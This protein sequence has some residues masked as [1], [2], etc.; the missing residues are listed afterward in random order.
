MPARSFVEGGT[1][2]S[3]GA[4]QP[5]STHDTANT[6][7]VPLQHVSMVSLMSGFD[8]DKDARSHA[9]C[10]DDQ[11]LSPWTPLLLGTVRNSPRL[12]T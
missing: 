7:V 3:P 8:L 4:G 12:L 11:L 6:D 2:A 10:L 5:Y 1:S 9:L